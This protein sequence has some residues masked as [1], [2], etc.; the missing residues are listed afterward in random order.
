M[1]FRPDSHRS[2]KRILFTDTIVQGTADE[3]TPSGTRRHKSGWVCYGCGAI[4]T[5]E[6]GR[7]FHCERVDSLLQIWILNSVDRVKSCP[8]CRYNQGFATQYYKDPFRAFREIT[9]GNVYV[10]AQEML[11]EAEPEGRK[12]IIFADNRQEAAFQAGWIQDRARR[13]RFRQLLWTA[14]APRIDLRSKLRSTGQDS[15]VE[16]VVS[17]LTERLLNDKTKAR[18]IAPEVF[19]EASESPF[20]RRWERALREFLTIQVLR[21][22]AASYNT[23]ASL[24]GWGKLGVLYYGVTPG[25]VAVESSRGEASPRR[26]QN[27]CAVARDIA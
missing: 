20:D 15:S 27:S 25:N 3:G 16:S 11:R 4:Y 22:L 5:G 17:V 6:V 1:L 13:Y 21:E 2:K 12:L 10:L 26:L 18:L 24:E 8:V 23:R 19:E 9:V 14:L 7:C